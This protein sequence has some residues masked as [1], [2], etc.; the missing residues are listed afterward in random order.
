V[1]GRAGEGGCGKAYRENFGMTSFASQRSC[2]TITASGV[3]MLMLTTAL[4]EA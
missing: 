3:P 4:S 1:N 2:S